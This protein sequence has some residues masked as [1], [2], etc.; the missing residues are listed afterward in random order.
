[1]LN[2]RINKTEHETLLDM[3]SL[4]MMVAYEAGADDAHYR[5]MTSMYNTILEMSHDRKNALSDEKLDMLQDKYLFPACMTF[6]KKMNDDIKEAVEVVAA[7]IESQV[8]R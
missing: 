5:S 8:I 1:M 3:M 6:Y 7:P 4:A 2:L